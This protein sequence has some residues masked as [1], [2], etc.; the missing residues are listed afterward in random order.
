[1]SCT[2]IIPRDELNIECMSTGREIVDYTVLLNGKVSDEDLQTIIEPFV[3]RVETMASKHA[4]MAINEYQ[5]QI[6]DDHEEEEKSKLLAAKKAELSELEPYVT[7]YECNK[8][9]GEQPGDQLDWLESDI[10][11]DFY[12]DIGIYKEHS[13]VF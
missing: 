1:M 4:D 11:K 7:V 2:D 3:D 13:R 5:G 8:Q 6:D 10:L 12:E 9:P